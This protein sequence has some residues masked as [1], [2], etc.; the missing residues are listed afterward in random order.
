MPNKLS[1]TA[2]A[3]Q[4]LQVEENPII[5]DDP[6]AAQAQQ[7]AMN[8]SNKRL[9]AA[10]AQR[11]QDERERADAEMDRNM[12]AAAEGKNMGGSML[13]PP[14][15]EGYFLGAAVKGAQKVGSKILKEAK[16]HVDDLK[17][18][19][20]DGQDKA[21]GATLAQRAARETQR[22][23][24]AMTGAGTLAL[25]G[26]ANLLSDDP[27]TITETE[28][29]EV[30]VY[31]IEDLPTEGAMIVESDKGEVTYKNTK[32]N[33]E[34][35]KAIK[36]KEE[37]VTYEDETFNTEAL[38]TA[39][40]D[41]SKPSK[42]S[43]SMGG[44]MN[45]AKG[46]SLLND[47]EREG[48]AKGTEATEDEDEDE[49][50]LPT[51]SGLTQ[52]DRDRIKINNRKAMENSPLYKQLKKEYEDNK[53]KNKEESAIEA[54]KR[55]EAEDE[56]RRSESSD[57]ATPPP[58]A[59]RD[60]DV[61]SKGGMMSYA[62]GGSM[63]VP[64]EM[65]AEQSMPVDTYDNI[66]PD[67]MAAAEASQLPDEEMESNYLTYVLNESLEPQDQE[68]L[69]SVLEGDERLSSIFD[70]VMD[71]AGEFSGEGK[72]DGPGTGVSDSIPARL[73]DGEF[74]VT[75]KATDEIGADNLQK[76][77]DEAEQ[78]YD[79][80]YMKKAFGGLTLDPMQDEKQMYGMDQMK[81]TQDELRKQML[82]ANRMPSVVR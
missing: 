40:S 35:K 61:F 24:G 32:L 37:E 67:E 55:K 7:D 52:E 47:P 51:L 76:M 38:K 13:M 23:T 25:I 78:A 39:L 59:P 30:P 10:A 65:E 12:R 34:L 64:P 80:G 45:Y 74:V 19:P 14:E 69:M 72:V 63:L 20:T 62:E 73:S 33:R 54:F 29:P 9:E 57:P 21:R 75:E 58:K 53:N 46:S 26:G 16:K 70:K 41:F 81:S 17:T 18:K 22:K 42:E 82:G 6:V 50:P 56:E 79:G 8:S 31:S 71:V 77:M 3:E 5:G 48:Y 15:R 60:P 27:A 11:V 68:Y 28:E 4:R 49:T 36:N 43:K 66:P 1:K 2:L 44:R